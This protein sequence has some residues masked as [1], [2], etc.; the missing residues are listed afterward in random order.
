MLRKKVVFCGIERLKCKKRGW[1][2]ILSS[3]ICT[4]I[5][6]EALFQ[7]QLSHEDGTHPKPASKFTAGTAGD[8]DGIDS[9]VTHE[10]EILRRKAESIMVELRGKDVVT[11]QCGPNYLHIVGPGIGSATNHILTLAHALAVQSWDRS[12]PILVLPGYLMRTL[13]A[14]DL[15]LL[16]ELY[17]IQPS[18]LWTDA[19]RA[20]VIS[21]VK[22]AVHIRSIKRVNSWISNRMFRFMYFLYGQAG[23]VD[24][25]L[26]DEVKSMPRKTGSTA[27]P[28]HEND[29]VITSTD[30]FLWGG[31]TYDKIMHAKRQR[32]EAK[33]RIMDELMGIGKDYHFDNLDWGESYNSLYDVGADHIFRIASNNTLVQAPHFHDSAMDES[34]R[35][36]F[37]KHVACVMAALWSS[38]GPALRKHIATVVPKNTGAEAKD[39]DYSATHR[40]F[41]ER[42]CLFV[43]RDKP[44]YAVPV[45]DNAEDH[46]LCEMKPTFARKMLGISSTKH[47]F[48]ASDGQQNDGMWLRDAHS[49]VGWQAHQQLVSRSWLD[50][51][52]DRNP[53]AVDSI[54]GF[55]DAFVAALGRGKFFGQP[56]STYSL[57]IYVLRMLLGRENVIIGGDYDIYYRTGAITWITPESF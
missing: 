55:A 33:A 49:T 47:V 15:T 51:Y 53:R 46:P 7:Y 6:V 44:V 20:T 4:A 54:G 39:L 38:P 22:H 2:W 28:L 32:E 42:T 57:Q 11:K 23:I 35:A 14:F 24:S 37:T 26:S 5:L 21:E 8:A 10:L 18:T 50:F 43:Y 12:H 17:C 13:D 34:S 16:K 48:L 41:F 56:R 52:L 3:F 31:E 25:R 45:P 40:R 27:G 19:D 30:M 1:L 29:L 36:F 9:M